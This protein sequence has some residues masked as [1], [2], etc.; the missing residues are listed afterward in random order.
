MKRLLALLLSV[1]MVL[2]L[3]AGCGGDG[4]SDDEDEGPKVTTDAQKDTNHPT[5]EPEDP[6]A[7]P[8]DPAE[9]TT[10]PSDSETK[11]G[12]NPGEEQGN[13]PVGT[14]LFDKDG[15]QV[16]YQG[17]M[18]SFSSENLRLEIIN[19]SDVGIIF[20]TEALV[21]NGVTVAVSCYKTVAHHDSSEELICIDRSDLDDWNITT[22][23]SIG[24]A[25][26]V[27]RSQDSNDVLHTVSYQL[28]IDGSGDLKQ[29]VDVSGETL[30]HHTDL[31]V[32]AKGVRDSFVGKELIL[33]VINHS[34]EDFVVNVDNLSVNGYTCEA[35]ASN[36][37]VRGTAGLCRVD[38]FDKN[39]QQQ[40]ITRIEEITFDLRAHFDSDTVHSC[41]GLELKNVEG[42][43]DVE[44]GEGGG[45]S[46]AM[47]ATLDSTVIYDWEDVVVTVVGLEGETR[48]PAVKI[49]LENNSS[50]NLY[51]SLDALVIN[52]VYIDAYE[53]IDASAGKKA[54][55]SIPISLEE[56]ER[57]GIETIATIT[58]V[59]ARLID[60]DSF[61]T[62]GEV[63]CDLVTNVGADYEQEVDLSG[64]E[65]ANQDDVRIL[66]KGLEKGDYDTNIVM[67]VENGTGSEIVVEL[68]ELKING[69]PVENFMY[70][71]VS[72]G[73]CRYLALDMLHSSLESEGIAEIQE[74]SIQL[75]VMNHDTYQ[76]VLTTEAISLELQAE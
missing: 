16:V 5:H 44:P 60:N 29:E 41:P 53:S 21:V 7:D 10:K 14:V 39:L 51:L 1:L 9:E 65:L 13:T 27:I 49:L 47:G 2:S 42:D 61:D 54:N 50:A 43:V 28:V 64:Q 17:M 25:E 62:L 46:S 40:G 35:Y 72:A 6:S 38:I 11:P 22:I 24:I 69:T 55:G 3:L 34:D 59:N 48:E 20:E 32:I 8:T 67:L 68:V 71:S 33:L 37:I 63:T 56:L 52:G 4:N 19:N 18:S 36:L 76:T 45:T 74:I 15:I 70:S 31:T 58:F 75:Q 30:A 23:R 12:E 73:S 66:F 26:A 57:A